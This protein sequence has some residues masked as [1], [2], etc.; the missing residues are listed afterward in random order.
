[1][2]TDLHSDLI[3]PEKMGNSFQ[4]K[5]EVFTKSFKYKIADSSLWHPESRWLFIPRKVYKVVIYK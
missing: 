2:K 4:T 3:K 1:M 5:K